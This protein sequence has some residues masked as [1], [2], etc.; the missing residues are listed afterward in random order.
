MDIK[1]IYKQ[2]TNVN[3]EEQKRLWD[4]R[5]K[6]YYG[7]YLVFCELYKKIVG[8]CKILMNLNIPTENGKTTEIDLLMIHETGIYVFEIKH[9]KGKIYGNDTGEIWTQY[10]RTVKNSVFKNP[11]LQNEYHIEAINKLFDNIPIKSVIVFTSSDCE[12]KVKNANENIDLCTLHDLN[13][14]LERRFNLNEIKYSME[15]IDT[16]FETLS[17]Y[18][19]MQEVVTYDGKEEPFVH[20]LEPIIKE[21]E[22]EKTNSI[23]NSNELKKTKKN[24]KLMS[25]A[26]AITCVIFTIF[27]VNAIKNNYDKELDKFKQNFKHVDEIGNEYIDALNEYVNVTNASFNDIS[28][29]VVSFSA[30]ISMSNDVYGI[31]LKENSKYIVMTNSGKVFEYDVFGEHLRYNRY[32]NKIGKGIREYG[33]L[34]RIQFYGVNENDITYIKITNIELFKLDIKQTIIKDNLE[35]ELYCK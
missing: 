27:S 25:I 9:Y 26:I 10:F 18:S 16:M 30:R 2:L 4:E 12:I 34:A 15:E 17:K 29:N 5:G 6:G 35:I 22:K 28:D 24:T 7:E 13:I 23:N 32:A 33:D 21:L 19:P 8:N 11:I 3:I 31:A 20:W 14:T 1:D